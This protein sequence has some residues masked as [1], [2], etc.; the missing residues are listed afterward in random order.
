LRYLEQTYAEIASNLALDEALLIAA[1]EHGAGPVLRIWEPR[2]VA[3]VLGASSR[4]LEDVVVDHCREDGVPIA[5]RSSGGGT[6]VVGPG[7]LNLTVVLAADAAPE[8]SAVDTTQR[9]VLERIA[10]SLRGLAPDVSVRGLGDLALGDRKFGGS[11]QRRLKRWLFVHFCLMY[12]FPIAMIT[13]C[14]HLPKRQP[15]YRAGRPHA[16]FLTNLDR[17]REQLIDAIRRGWVTSEPDSSAYEIPQRLVDELVATR[18]G[19]ETWVTRF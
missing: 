10:D 11:A 15:L 8:L 3:V 6:V 7:T 17:P 18:F 5:R 19:D 12:A 4:L 14:L 16:S 1:E 13:R 9:Y 2:G